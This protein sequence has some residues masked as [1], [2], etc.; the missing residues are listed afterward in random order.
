MESQAEIRRQTERRLIALGHAAKFGDALSRGRMMA[1]LLAAGYAP[2]PDESDDA[3]FRRFLAG[4]EHH[5][6]AP[7]QMAKFRPLVTKPHLRQ[8]EI[9]AQPTLKSMPWDGKGVFW[10][11]GSAAFVVKGE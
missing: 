6:A 4:T 10:R 11:Q 2:G 8:A 7:K 5:R 9:D 1:A 3:L